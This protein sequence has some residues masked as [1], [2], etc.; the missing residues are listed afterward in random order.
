MVINKSSRNRFFAALLALALSCAVFSC[1]SVY[2]AGFSDI[3]DGAWYYTDVESLTGKGIINGYPDGSFRPSSRITCAEFIKL[4]CAAMDYYD[5]SMN[6]SL[7]GIDIEEAG[8]TSEHW[9]NPYVFAA[10]LHGIIRDSDIKDGSFVY[11]KPITRNYMAKLYVRAFELTVSDEPTAIFS[12]D[13][14]VYAVA[15]AKEYLIRGYP[16]EDGTREYRGYSFLSRAEAASMIIRA[17]EYRDNPLEYK[18]STVIDN[19]KKYSVNTKDELIELFCAINYYC[20][21]SFTFSSALPYSKWSEYYELAQYLYPEYFLSGG[22]ECNYYPGSGVYS[23]ILN[24]SLSTDKLRLMTSDALKKADN[25]IDSL[26]GTDT[27]IYIK[28]LSIHN[29][30]ALNCEYDYENYARQAIPIESFS[31]YGALVDG[32]A[33]CQGYTAAFNMLCKAAGIKSVGVA[34]IYSKTGESH[35]WNMLCID[36]NTLYVDVTLDDKPTSY[37]NISYERFLVNADSMKMFGYE[38]DTQLYDAEQYFY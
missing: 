31:A 10:W 27:D 15:A 6:D 22:F 33:V 26:F 19:A 36:G 12:D 16:L 13:A 34:G 21:D 38:W 14:S 23:I 17:M 24:Y 1:F 30:L 4:F 18:M 29:Y 2:A 37:G 5:P 7:P 9:A 8:G 32:V 35:S 11:D 3:S 25:V 20:L 28:L